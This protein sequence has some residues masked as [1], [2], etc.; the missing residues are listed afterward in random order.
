M[1][2]FLT[3]LSFIFLFIACKS[4]TVVMNN[5]DPS[6]NV[7]PSPSKN[8]VIMTSSSSS[9]TITSLELKETVEFLASDALKGRNTGS[10]GIEHAASFIE[11]KFKNFKL[12]PYFETYRDSFKI[13]DKNAYN[14]VGFLEGHDKNLKEEVI[15][16]GAHY[17]H[18]GYGKVVANDSIANGANDNASGTSGVLAM[19]KYFSETKSHGRSLMFVLFSAEEMGLLGS[20]HLAEK[21]KLENIDLYT[22][23]NFEMIGVPFPDRD[24]VAFVTGYDISNMALKIND[25]AGSNLVGLS[26]IAKQYQ[27]FKASDNHPFYEAFKLPCQ[28]IASCDLSNYDYYH[29]VGDEADQLDYNH[30]ASLIN[31]ML[32]VIEKMSHTPTKEIVLYEE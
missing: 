16:I 23:L 17:D 13:G 18:I 4:T 11:K 6:Q 20:K 22:M 27:L 2:H 14:I 8:D 30:M 12:K 5:E 1:K 29:H 9:K 7:I 26:E 32:P 21:L 25:Y 15:I 19:S 24:Y 28:T 10:E 3:L 31:K